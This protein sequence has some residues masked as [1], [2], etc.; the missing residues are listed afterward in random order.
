M[1]L[2]SREIFDKF[3]GFYNGTNLIKIGI[4]NEISFKLNLN[5]I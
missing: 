5:N 3:D 1:I 4:I 2:N